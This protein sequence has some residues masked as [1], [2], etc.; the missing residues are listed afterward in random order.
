[1]TRLRSPAQRAPQTL[2]QATVLLSRY[3]Q[4]S[5]ELSLIEANRLAELVTANAGA[6]KLA[7]PLIAELKDIVKQLKPWW[8]ASIDALTGGKKKSI[9]LA[10]CSIGY[11]MTPPKVTYSEGTDAEAVDALRATDLAEQ[12]IRVTYSLDKAAILKLLDSEDPKPVDGGDID[13]AA[14]PVVSPKQIVEELGFASKQ[15]EQFFVD[16]VAPAPLAVASVE[17]PDAHQVA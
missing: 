4:A 9:E 11:R 12:L 3:A 8:A 1:M 5:A 17:D 13:G 14:E 16:V 7:V 2:D 15:T 10:G 6:D